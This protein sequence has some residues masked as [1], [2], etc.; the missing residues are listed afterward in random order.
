MAHLATKDGSFATTFVITD[1]V[2]QNKLKRLLR[3]VNDGSNRT[4][5][6]STREDNI[7]LTVGK[8]F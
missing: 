5:C 3:N 2:S 7:V 1:V 4:V 6:A 8:A